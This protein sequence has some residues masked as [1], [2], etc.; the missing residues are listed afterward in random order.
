MLLVCCLE[1]ESR[2][3]QKL[4]TRI[5]STCNQKGWMDDRRTYGQMAERILGLN[6]GCCT[7][8]KRN[9]GFICSEGSLNRES[10]N[11]YL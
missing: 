6:I 5:V 9:V 1:E 7:K 2:G 11:S 8:E 4:S 3:E 10:G